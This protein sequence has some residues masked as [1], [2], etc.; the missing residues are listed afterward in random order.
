MQTVYARLKA[1]KPWVQ[2]GIESRGIWRP[3]FPAQI[4]GFDAYAQIYADS[5]LW[6]ASGWVDYLSPQLYW[7]VAAPA[8]SFPALLGR[9]RRKTCSTAICGP[10]WPIMKRASGLPTTKSPAN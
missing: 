4:R 3:N 1:A 2:F 5:R 9:S 8:Q 7:P 6:L 10:A